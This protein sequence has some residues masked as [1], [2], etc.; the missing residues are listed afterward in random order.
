MLRGMYVGATGMVMNQ[1]Q[2]NV[3]ANNLANVN[4]TAFK[5][6]EAVFK[7]FPEM[8]L[9]RSREDGL[10]H[11]PLGSFDMAPHRGKAGDGG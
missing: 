5:R 2:M 7:A 4:K 8:L 11:V 3:I 10:G 6:D 1:H 9:R